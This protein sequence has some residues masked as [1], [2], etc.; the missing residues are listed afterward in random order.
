MAR[1]QRC[2]AAQYNTHCKTLQQFYFWISSKLRGA[3]SDGH[4]RGV[5]CWK[6]SI[7]SSVILLQIVKLVGSWLLRTCGRL[8]WQLTRYMPTSSSGLSSRLL[9]LKGIYKDT[10]I[11]IYIYVYIYV[12]IHIHIFCIHIHTFCIHVHIFIHQHTYMYTKTYIYIHEHLHAYVYITID[13]ERSLALYRSFFLSPVLC[14]FSLPPPPHTQ[15]TFSSRLWSSILLCRNLE[16]APSLSVTLSLLLPLSPPFL[17]SLSLSLAHALSL[18]HT[19]THFSLS[20]ELYICGER[21]YK[22]MQSVHV[23]VCYVGS[24]FGDVCMNTLMYTHTHYIAYVHTCIQTVPL[25]M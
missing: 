6:F 5:S 7:I 12:C 15:H 10:H 17:S 21:V 8:W 13:V 22:S 1:K 24:F 18:S 20:S 19:H 11:Y 9:M 25:D 3:G 23:C 14:V 4:E 2:T 16:R